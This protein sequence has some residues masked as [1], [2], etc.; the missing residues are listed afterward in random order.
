[1]VQYFTREGLQKLKEELRNL[2]TV[3]NK[4]IVKLIAEAA[5]FGDLKENSAYHDARDKNNYLAHKPKA[6]VQVALKAARA[7]AAQLKIDDWL[8]LQAQGRKL[9]LAV[10]EPALAE[11]QKLDGCYVIKTDLLDAWA[12]AQVVHDRYKDLTLVEQNFR[13]SKTVELELRPV[14]VRLEA[15]TR[16]HVLV[17]M[18]AHRLIQELQPCWAQENLTVEEGIHELSSLCVTEVVVG[19]TVRDQLVPEGRAQV[20]RLLDLAK[21]QIPKKLRYTGR[22][23]PTKKNLKQSRTTRCK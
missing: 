5:A 12:T 4:R 9:V 13:T 22:I 10:D 2:K 20:K 23:V 15:S 3:E 14:H 16:G 21:V 19:G 8:S 17:V 18:L 6:R 1:M 11:A 7:R